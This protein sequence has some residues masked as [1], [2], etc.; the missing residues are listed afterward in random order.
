MENL[1]IKVVNDE[2]QGNPMTWDN[3]KEIHPNLTE[4]NYKKLGYGKFTRK[5]KPNDTPTHT[6]E[7]AG[8]SMD[9]YGNVVETFSAIERETPD[10]V[11]AA[12]QV[13]MRRNALLAQTDWVVTKASETGVA[14]STEMATYRES[15]RDITAHTN[16]PFLEEAD[17]PT[18]P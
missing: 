8:Y 15:L 2:P 9:G 13:R 11:M 12:G 18:K 14:I 6:Y 17:W 4:A 10:E 16:F 7:S 3:V 5:P 1:L